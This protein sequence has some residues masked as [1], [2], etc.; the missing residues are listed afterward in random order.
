MIHIPQM[1]AKFCVKQELIRRWD[2]RT[3]RTVSSY[4]I[5]YL[6]RN[7][8]TP[9]VLRN[10]FEVTRTIS[11][12]HRFTKSALRILLLSIFRVSSINYSLVC[13]LPIHTRS[14]ANAEGPLAHYQLKSCKM[15]HKYS[16]YCIWKGLQPVNDL[17]GHSR[18]LPYTISY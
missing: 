7:Y 9:V 13:S 16:I 6:A 18:S 10:I 11:N 4:M 12:G 14:S 17:Q 8:D 2:T 3:W 5:T 15:L 1:Q